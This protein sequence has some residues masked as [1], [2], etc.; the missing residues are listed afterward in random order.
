MFEKNIN[1]IDIQT[2]AVSLIVVIVSF[3]RLIPHIHNFS[4][5]IALAIFGVF[6]YKN[7]SFSYF[8]PLLSVWF[9]DLILNNFIYALTD[10]FSFFYDGFYWQY[11]AYIII[12][13]IS[14]NYKN[15]KI[16]IPNIFYLALSSSLIFFIISNFGVWLSSGMYTNDINGLFSCYIAAIPFYKGT[17]FGTFFYTP[18]LFGLYFLLQKKLNIFKSKSILY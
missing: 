14:Y 17:L 13:F 2:I 8:I 15:R 18:I 5:I 6:H 16:N 1:L 7:K 11:L 10:N 4:P 12:I 9:S 3:L